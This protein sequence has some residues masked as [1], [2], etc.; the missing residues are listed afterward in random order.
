MYSFRRLCERGVECLSISL[1]IA[2]KTTRKQKKKRLMIRFLSVFALFMMWK[3]RMKGR[4]VFSSFY[5]IKSDELPSI[6]LKIHWKMMDV[7]SSTVGR[8]RFFNFLFPRT[9]RACQLSFRFFFVFH[10]APLLF[11]PPETS[12]KL[13]CTWELLL[14]SLCMLTKSILVKK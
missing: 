14:H 12:N 5:V 3:E 9:R 1:G 10:L 6:A 7:A 8:N 13:M 11:L 2:S 4:K